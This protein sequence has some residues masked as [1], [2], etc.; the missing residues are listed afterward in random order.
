MCP[1]PESPL[2][3]HLELIG[4]LYLGPTSSQLVLLLLPFEDELEEETEE[5]TC[6]L[7][8]RVEEHVET[9]VV[10]VAQG[11]Q[12]LG[13]RLAYLE[14]MRRLLQVLGA[15]ELQV[16]KVVLLSEHLGDTLKTLNDG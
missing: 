7:D 11:L 2:Q 14:L 8:T 6:L 3:Q 4:G 13:E 9:D 12:V 15:E 1:L 10:V 16:Y 5:F